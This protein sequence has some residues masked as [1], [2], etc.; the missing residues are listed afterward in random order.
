MVRS[1][2]ASGIVSL[3]REHSKQ[4]MSELMQ[5]GVPESAAVEQAAQH[6]M[7]MRQLMAQ[8]MSFHEAHQRTPLGKAFD[9]L[10]NLVQN[11]VNRG[12]S[13]ERAQQQAGTHM[14]TIQRHLSRGMSLDEAVNTVMSRGRPR[15]TADYILDIA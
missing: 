10:A 2:R 8:G 1:N 7:G 14:A 3:M 12:L 9:V 5:A 4:V 11:L 15:V 13:Q 6:I